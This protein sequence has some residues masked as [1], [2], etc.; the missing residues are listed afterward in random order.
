MRRQVELIEDGGNVVQQTRLYD[1]DRNETRAMRGKEDAHDYRYFPDPDLPPLVIADAWVARVRDAMPELPAAMRERV[2]AHY[3]L[4]DYDALALTSSKQIAAYFDAVVAR[5][6]ASHAKLAANWITGDVA[7]LVNEQG[8]GDWN[9]LPV[10][11]ATLGALLERVAE[12]R[13]TAKQ[14]K[15]LLGEFAFD[16]A[17]FT[18]DGASTVDVDRW[19]AER[20][21]DQISDSGA[22]EAA[23]DAIL[24]KNPS[25]VADYRSGKDKLFGFFVGQAM[26]ATQGKANPQQLNELLRTK[27]AG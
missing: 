15:G 8:H 23:I 27:L 14:G 21:Y 7:R 5:V 26:K 19:I 6:G 1:P 11:A 20:G 2:T 9:R 13:I 25:Q 3:G 4:S 18:A 17:A 16:E 12:G 24:A 10:A 22:L